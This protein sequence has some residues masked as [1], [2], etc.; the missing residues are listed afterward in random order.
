MGAGKWCQMV[1]ILGIEGAYRST[2]GKF[3]VAVVQAVLLFGLETW[4]VTTCIKNSL[5]GFHHREFGRM[6]DRV[7]E[8]QLNGIWVYPSIGEALV[9][10]I[11]EEIRVYITCRKN[12]VLR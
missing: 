12:T 1:N 4:M 8:H 5:I 11:L 9:M 2:Y 3:S 10:A 6:A 7:P